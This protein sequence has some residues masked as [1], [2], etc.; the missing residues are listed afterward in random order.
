MA[1]NDR[2]KQRIIA[3]VFEKRS[4][5]SYVAHV[6]IWEDAPDGQGRKPRYIILSRPSSTPS[7]DAGFIHKSKLNTNGTFSVGKTWRLAELKGIHVVTSTAFNITLARTYRWQT[8]NPADQVAFLK[9]TVDLFRSLVDAP[10]QLVG[11][12]ETSNADP[13]PPPDDPS[14]PSTPLL[15]LPNR[16]P[17]NGQPPQTSHIIRTPSRSTSPAGSINNHST[18]ESVVSSASGL[19]PPSPSHQSNVPSALRP[20]IGRRPSIGTPPPSAAG[21]AIAIPSSLMPSRTHAVSPRPSLPGH[22]PAKPSFDLLRASTP[23]SAHLTEIRHPAHSEPPASAYKPPSRTV[24]P[25]PPENPQMRREHNNR[26]SFFDPANQAALDRLVAGDWGSEEDA[27]GAEVT[28]E[29]TMISVEEMLEGYDWA[30]DDVFGRRSAKGAADLVE[31]RLLDELMALDKANIHSFL[32]SDDRVNVVIKYLDEAVGEIDAMDSLI[33]SYKIHLNAVGDDISFIQSQRRGLQVQMQNQHVLLSELENLLKTVQ[34]SPEA[35]VTL[36]QESLEKQSGIQRLEEA[37]TE[38]YKAL[39]A[40]QDTEMAATMERLDEYKTYNAQFCKRIFDYLSIMIVAQ[41]KLILDDN[42]GIVRPKG[43]GRPI[44]SNHQGMESYLGRYSG[45]LL[46]LKEMD[47]SV[48]SKFCAAYFSA[49]SDLHNTQMKGLFSTYAG[50]LKKAPEEDTEQSFA[51]NHASAKGG[52]IRRA[53]TIVRGPME[54]RTRE[55]ERGGQ[56]GEEYGAADALGYILEQAAPQIYRE[57]DFVADFLQIN[58]AGL[59][60]ADYAGL[61]NYFRRQ[62]ARSAGLSQSTTKL[63]R[64]AMDLIFG[65]LPTELKQW[66]DIAVTKDAL[67]VVG[68]IACLERFLADADERGSSFFLQILEKQHLRLKGVFDRHINQQIKMVDETKLTSKKRKGV[69]HFIKYFPVYVGRVE[70]QLVG[71]DVLEIRG[72]VD[73]A[74]EKIVH[75]MFECLKHMA[76]LDGDGEDKGQLN[77]HVLIVEN[78]HYFVAEISHLATGSVVGF[79]KQAE[80]IYNENLAAYVKIVLRRPFAKLIEFFEG[81]E[82][83]LKTTAPSEVQKNSNY[84]KSSLKKVLKEFDGKDVRKHIDVLFRRVEKHFTEA[85]EKAT[86]EESSGIA[87]GTVMV[88]V[89]KACEEELQRMTEGFNARISQCY[90]DSGITMEYTSSDVESGFK[91]HRLD[92]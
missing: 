82:R 73:S 41:A 76:T 78:M 52:A 49:T 53:G 47:E 35:L 60:F 54:A 91:R 50:M 58:D 72:H 46:Y 55:R 65:F 12:D 17:D 29:A 3:S 83:L 1:D 32:E 69:A 22:T 21:A 40:S 59:T 33:S 7:D 48:Y 25:K 81:L 26:V 19:R 36:T 64:G 27:E 86:R 87:P 37:A 67:Q 56:A 28:A 2:A 44:I 90:A 75:S 61:D 63:V 8:E 38:L 5:E 57:G 16:L 88:G 45:L 31:A 20:R 42:G 70:Q 66:I 62:A 84:S 85:E 6:K 4:T 92:S 77:Y 30:S 80:V 24:T 23:S 51:Q 74:Y 13:V 9:V 15:S 71:A 39:Q 10:L 79:L 68:V 18:R 89:W 34:V 14:L 43:R 11:V